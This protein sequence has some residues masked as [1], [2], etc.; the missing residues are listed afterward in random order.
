M[1]S[2]LDAESDDDS[3]QFI[4][5]DKESEC[6]DDGDFLWEKLAI[7]TS[8]SDDP[9]EA[10]AGFVALFMRSEDD[11]LFN[12]IMDHV[13]RAKYKFLG[14]EEAV[15]DNYIAIVN[16][17]GDAREKFWHGLKKEGENW[18]C[19]WFS[20]KDCDCEDCEGLSIRDLVEVFIKLFLEM[21]KDELIQNMESDIDD[22]EDLPFCVRIHHAIKK[23]KHEIEERLQEARIKLDENEWDHSCFF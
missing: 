17:V 6:P 10:F 11:E 7:L 21:Q 23:Y 9:V 4:E 20:G 2:H 13:T 5:S 18:K 12:R 3:V 15:D 22:M 16:A 1:E 14:I 19:E 8:I